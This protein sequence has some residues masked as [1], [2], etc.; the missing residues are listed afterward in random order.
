MTVSV[1]TPT[2]DVEIDGN[3]VTAVVSGRVTETADDATK[4]AYLSFATEPTWA[5]GDTLEITAGG[6]YNH[7]QRFYGTI[8]SGEKLNSDGSF[9]LTAYGPLWQ[10]SR[11]SN[12]YV[13]GLTLAQIA[14]PLSTEEEIV[15]AA[16]AIGG[17]ANIGTIEGTGL[18]RGDL[19]PAPFAWDNGATLLSY[20]RG[21]DAASLGYRLVEE[22]ANI[23]RRLFSRRPAVTPDRTFTEGVDIFGGARSSKSDLERFHAWSVTGFKFSGAD[24]IFTT[25]PDPPGT[26]AIRPF[27]SDMIERALEADPG[28]GLSAEAVLDWLLDEED[29]DRVRVYGLSTPRDEDVLIGETHL[30]ASMPLLGVSANFVVVSRTIEFSAQ[31]FTQTFD[32]EGGV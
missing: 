31:W 20:I 6:G 11:Y 22:G 7:V 19:A 24:A 27:Q 30:I 9:Q 8:V 4:R 26:V 15:E 25:S 29:Y 12:A 32:Y 13:N 21:I 3:P 28:N 16:L 14:P 23:S 2:L 1:W 10:L 5:K 17:I 18:I